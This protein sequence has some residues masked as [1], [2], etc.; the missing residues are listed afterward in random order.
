MKTTGFLAMVV[1]VLAEGCSAVSDPRGAGGGGGDELHAGTGG[2]GG[3]F[4][5]ATSGAGS[6]SSSGGTGGAVP[7]SGP[8]DP[9]P[10]LCLSTG[11]SQV[12]DQCCVSEGGWQSTCT[13]P[14]CG[15]VLTCDAAGSAMVPMCA[16]PE[17]TCFDPA[18]GCVKAP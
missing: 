7:D 8:P 9:R 6:T 1:L 16:C 18:A 10:G 13:P 2:G 3:G 14:H 12:T 17:G 15:Q 11:G 5:L 4:V